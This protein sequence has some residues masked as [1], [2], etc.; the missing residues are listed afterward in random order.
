[1]KSPRARSKIRQWFTKERREESIDRGTEHIAKLMRKQ[2]VPLKRLLTNEA[3]ESVAA[4]L[5]YAD[6]GALF[7]AVGQDQIS[8]EAVVVKLIAR[9]GAT[10]PWPR[11]PLRGRP[12]PPSAP[13]RTQAAGRSRGIEVQ[14]QPDVW[15]KLARCCTPVPPTRSWG[16]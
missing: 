5:H 11:R 2:G 4:D 7:A 1:M 15:V 16:S 10:R 13:A 8:A 14:G 12:L 6:I 3:V 9:P